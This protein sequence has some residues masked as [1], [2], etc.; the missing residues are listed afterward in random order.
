MGSV[1]PNAQAV[2]NRRPHFNASPLPHPYS[3]E[4]PSMIGT[5]G[6]S[7]YLRNLLFSA[8]AIIPAIAYCTFTA[9]LHN[10]RD[11]ATLR[12][13]DVPCVTPWESVGGCGTG[14][15]P[16]A[17]SGSG[18]RWVGQ[19]VTGAIVDVELM[20]SRTV[21]T[22]QE[23]SSDEKNKSL[24]TRDML[25]FSPVITWRPGQN[26][27]ALSL[28]YRVNESSQFGSVAGLGDLGLSAARSFGMTGMLSATAMVSAPTGGNR[29]YTRSDDLFAPDM[30]LGSGV[31]G[32]GLEVGMDLDREWGIITGSLGYATGLFF[33]ETTEYSYDTTLDRGVSASSRLA[34]ARA[35]WGFKND[36]NVIFP[37]QLTLQ[38]GVGIRR[39]ILTH[40]ISGSLSLPMRQGELE[41]RRYDV[42]R[43][44]KD[45]ALAAENSV[46]GI[47]EYP[48]FEDKSAAQAYADT[49]HQTG[50][51]SKYNDPVVMG[52]NHE[53]KWVV[54]DRQ[55][56][57]WPQSPVLTLH[58]SLEKGDIDLP[59]LIGFSLPV[60]M[61]F[62]DW[63]IRKVSVIGL[64]ATLGMQFR[65][66]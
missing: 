51:A 62:D 48:F 26:D 65:I 4:M 47:I 19:G 27:I 55:K 18:L 54:E 53:G 49:A 40:G 7:K 20:A 1:G 41:V 21:N 3:G 38:G 39:D 16:T 22:S 17:G 63:W 50:G 9:G 35:G 29:L 31:F 33:L 64:S 61:D 32:A 52:H 37:D 6:V 46:P 14:S 42:D 30:Q 43:L 58:Y 5:P 11:T 60:Q 34:P 36:N 28:P 66:Y 2:S 8:M 10:R 24:L 23:V 59:V 12:S 13:R 44:F 45:S 15:S 57:E 25:A 56:E